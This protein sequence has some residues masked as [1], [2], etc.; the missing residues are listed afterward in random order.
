MIRRHVAAETSWNAMQVPRSIHMLST[1]AER[2]AALLLR[3]GRWETSTAADALAEQTIDRPIYVTGLA[4]SGSTILLELLAAH[5]DVA[6][7]Q[8]RDFPLIPIPL[9]WNW[10]FDRASRKETQPVERAHKDRIAVTPESPE[11][12]EEILWMAFFADCHDAAT[13]NV[14]SEQASAPEF[15]AFYRDHIRKL[16]LL[17][18]GKR[19]LAKGN[20]N[21]SR[22]GY[23]RKLFPDARFVVPVRDPVGHIAS[24]MKQHRLFCEEETRDPRI[25]DYMRRAGHFEFGL[26]RRPINLADAD[27]VRRIEALWQRGDEVEGWAVY[28]GA[29]YGFVADLVENDATVARQTLLVDYENLCQEPARVLAQVYRHCELEIAPSALQEQAARISAPSYYKSG[30]SDAEVGLIGAA[31]DAARARI[32]KLVEAQAGR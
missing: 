8:Y 23:L 4:R 7:H 22:L 11:A 17:R 2:H 20:Y 27:T 19:Y 10:F 28:W 12:M 30:F 15:E 26:N 13:S 5:P 14:L 24:L 31:T 1:L 18:Q 32:K 3:L 21:I 6:T 29:V 25:L 16:L 9:W